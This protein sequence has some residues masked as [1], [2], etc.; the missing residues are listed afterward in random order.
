MQASQPR[1]LCVTP[2]WLGDSIVALP[3]LRQLHDAGVRVDLLARRGTAR[4][5]ADAIGSGTLHD[6]G[7][8]GRLRRY[9]AA[10]ALRGQRFDAAIVMPPSWSAAAVA[11]ATG[12]RERVG[13]RGNGRR[14]WLTLALPRAGRNTHLAIAY[15]RS[16]RAALRRLGVPDE[17][18][19]R[20]NGIQPLAATHDDAPP[21]LHAYPSVSVRADESAAADRLLAA[22][23]VGP[24]TGVLI[25]APGAHYGSAKRYP[26]ERFAAAA[27][28][29]A[30]RLRGAVVVV[31]GAAD[32]PQAH[33]LVSH[34]PTAID[35]TGHTDLGTLIGLLARGRGVLSNDS[36][37]M[38]LGAALGVPVLGIFGSTN[39]LWTRPLGRRAGWV[40]H[41][42][43][44]AP[45]YR[46]T[47]P[48]DFPCMLGLEPQ[49]IAEKLFELIQLDSDRIASTSAPV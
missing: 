34:L 22:H 20:A 26:A 32:A 15:Q 40:A 6:S 46:R 1:I 9:R 44:C 24:D 43:P 5:F 16:A 2:S 11:W 30:E 21:G 47:C 25:V 36:G 13:E 23:A 19:R 18:L 3:A 48:I 38:H 10:W 31:G 12:A 4:V 49:T 7:A 45:C 42:V 29:L 35:L 28:Q 14:A 33:E 27:R 8:D 17:A 37:V 41:S 39:P